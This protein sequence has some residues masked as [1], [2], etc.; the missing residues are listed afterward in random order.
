MTADKFYFFR[1]FYESLKELPSDEFKTIISAMCEKAFY[2]KDAELQGNLKALYTLIEPIIMNSI[3]L[4]QTR[5]EQGRKGGAPKGNTNATKVKQT[6]TSKIKQG[7]A[8]KKKEKENGLM[9]IGEDMD[10]KKI[11]PIK[12][13]RFIPPTLE[14]VSQYCKEQCLSI[15]PEIFI[16]YYSS[17]GWK[18]GRSTMKDWKATVNMWEHRK[19]DSLKNNS[20]KSFNTCMSNSYSSAE[21]EELEKKLLDN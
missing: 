2:D 9:D 14:E 11:T 4:S 16:D 21:F 13:Q 12:N 15:S 7:Q 19:Q 20:S 5:S 17:N 6:K 10:N 1:S 3:I 8:E 18:V